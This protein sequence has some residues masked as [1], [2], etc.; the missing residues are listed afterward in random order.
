M[1]IKARIISWTGKPVI[2]P[3]LLLLCHCSDSPEIKPE[4]TGRIVLAEDFSFARCAYCPYAEDALDSL[5]REYGDSLAVLVYHRRQ[6]GDTLS[7][8]YVAVRE[9][10]YQITSS[11]TVVFDGTH[12]VQTEDPDQDYEVYKNNIVLER[13]RDAKLTMDLKAEIVTNIVNL[14]LHTEVKDS[15]NSDSCR[16][17][18][19]IYEGEVFF[20]Q[21]GAPDSIFD[22]VVRK[23]LPSEQGIPMTLAFPDSLT[24]EENFSVSPDWDPDKIGVVAFIQDMKTKEVLQATV[25][26]RIQ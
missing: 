21:T 18:F 3:F 7:P 16:L 20:K 4:P 19:V 14:T 24:N 15:V 17:F 1:K 22:Y 5:A 26:K 12:I 25:I 11:P 13:N 6:L 9:S 23:I 10:L 2:L 8:A